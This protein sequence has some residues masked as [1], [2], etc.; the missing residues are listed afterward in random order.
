MRWGVFGSGIKLKGDAECTYDPANFRLAYDGELCSVVGM[1]WD[2]AE[3]QRLQDIA[4]AAV[5]AYNDYVGRKPETVF[6]KLADY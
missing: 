6:L 5:K 1:S 3:A 4:K 2:Y